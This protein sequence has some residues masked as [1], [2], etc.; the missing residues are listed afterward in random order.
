MGR[1]HGIEFHDVGHRCCRCGRRGGKSAAVYLRRG[2]GH[3]AELDDGPLLFND[4]VSEFGAEYPVGTVLKGFGLSD[5]LVFFF[6]QD[7]PCICCS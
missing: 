3:V 2:V 4:R 5:L 6:F 7:D 1:H